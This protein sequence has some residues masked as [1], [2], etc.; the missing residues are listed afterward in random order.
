[1]DTMFLSASYPINYEAL[2]A[3]LN[4]MEGF[5]DIAGCIPGVSTL[6]ALPRQ[7]IGAALLVSFVGLAAL[8]L[9]RGIFVPK[10]EEKWKLNKEGI[11][12]ITYAWR[13]IKMIVWAQIESVPII[14]NA[15]VSLYLY[16]YKGPVFDVEKK[17]SHVPSLLRPPPGT[18]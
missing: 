8:N 11:K 7:L 3:V 1:M 14:G 9:F 16:Y 18:I 15:V 4:G 12:L 13:G 10:D 2:N 17:G 6:S 5:L